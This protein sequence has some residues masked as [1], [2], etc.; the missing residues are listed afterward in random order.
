MIFAHLRILISTKELILFSVSGDF[1]LREKC[2]ILSL[3]N[4]SSKNSQD[5]VKRLSENEWRV[6]AEWRARRDGLESGRDL[7]KSRQAPELDPRGAGQNSPPLW[8]HLAAKLHFQ[9]QHKCSEEDRKCN[10]CEG[11]TLIRSYNFKKG[12]SGLKVLAS[13]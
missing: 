10:M 4:N 3:H 9:H 13:Q 5:K 7:A 2:L 6:T 12:P 11:L 8:R 1:V